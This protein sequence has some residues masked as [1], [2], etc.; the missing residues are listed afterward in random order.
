MRRRALDYAEILG[1][2]IRI[3]DMFLI[4]VGG[5]LSY[6]IHS[7]FA[8][9]DL[10]EAYRVVISIQVLVA[11]ILFSAFNVYVSWRGKSLLLQFYTL[12]Q[13]WCIAF[14]VLFGIAFLT[15]TGGMFSREWAI[16][17]FVISGVCLLLLRLAV[18]KVLIYC[19]EHKLNCKKIIIIGA[20]SIG[21]EIARRIQENSWSGLDVIRF[22]DTDPTMESLL[23]ITVESLDKLNDFKQRDNV[24][25]IWIALPLSDEEKLSAV[26][27]E[28]EHCTLNI[29]FMPSLL[30]GDKLLSHP[31]NRIVGMAVIDLSITPMNDA[32]RI[33]KWLEDKLLSLLI[34]MM[35]SPL[36]LLIAIGVKLSSPGPIIYKQK[37]HGWDGRVFTVYKF[38]SMRIHQ[39][40]QGKVTQASR[41][42]ARVTP[43]GAILRKYNLDELPQ[44]INVLQGR[45][46][47]VGPRPHAVEHNEYYKQEIE[48]YMRRHKVKPGVTGWAQISGW[49]GET[50]T[51]EKMQKRVEYDLYYIDHWSLWFDLK[52]I[53]LTVLRTFVDKQAF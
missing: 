42:D 40:E 6:G 44:F 1:F 2:L 8:K 17:W 46:S 5:W 33:V 28:L 41:G 34:L 35:I 45:M 30:M 12:I 10:S 13:A 27:K 7:D 19:R 21:R 25:E 52:I 47:I 53:V 26:L 37:R 29:R 38:R 32:N 49:R 39:E 31:I 24:D 48:H 50:D 16:Y 4:V 23:G 20:N 36:M 15:Q 22:F 9:F 14:L 51:L 11:L 18:R 3:A 43:L